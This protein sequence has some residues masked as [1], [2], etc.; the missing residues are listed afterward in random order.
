MAGLVLTR[1]VGEAIQVDTPSGPVKFT[2]HQIKGKQT[3]I[4]LKCNRDWEIHRI[5]TTGEIER[6]EDGTPPKDTFI[7]NY[8]PED[9]INKD[10]K[11]LIGV[12]ELVKEGYTPS[13]VI[14]G[15]DVTTN[16]IYVL[17]IISA[18]KIEEASE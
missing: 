5:D 18:K 2:L 9:L 3:R 7:Y 13:K 11:I 15:K 6:R 4:G 8:Q 10:L 16:K 1:K 12:D 17:R 14:M